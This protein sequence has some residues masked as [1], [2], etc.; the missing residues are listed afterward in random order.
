MSALPKMIERHLY[1]EDFAAWS[2]EQAA[3]L[4]AGR[5]A[6]L[7]LE[8][9]A[10]ELESLMKSD[11]RALA[12]HLQVV[13]LHLLKWQFQPGRRGSSWSTSIRNGRIEAAA[14]LADSPSFRR[15]VPELVAARYPT[16]RR[17]AAD[18]TDLPLRTFPQDCPYAVEQILD[19]EFLPE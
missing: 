4:R 11:R 3:L 16:A 12:S 19:P 8:N 9:I 13:L 17:N 14:I 10:E 18:E 15:Q 1:D 5:V 2:S 6:E 7:D